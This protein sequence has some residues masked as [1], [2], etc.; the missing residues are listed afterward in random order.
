VGFST[1]PSFSNQRP[2]EGSVSTTEEIISHDIPVRQIIIINDNSSG[3]DS[4]L[5]KFNATETFATLK[6]Q[7]SVSMWIR[8]RTIII[9]AATSTVN[10]R[11]NAVG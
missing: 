1:S 5:F 2:T 7:E 11:I 10:Y 9:R 8:A 4:L 3:G 6:A